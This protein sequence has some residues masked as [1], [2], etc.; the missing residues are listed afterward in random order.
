MQKFLAID[1]NDIN[2]ELLHQLVKIYYPNFLFLKAKNGKYGIELAT[3]EKP[4]LIL[5]DILMPEMNGYEVCEILKNTPE[6]KHIPILMVSALGNDPTERTKGL[7]VGA[8]AFISKPFRQTELQA[9]I[10]VALRI[11]TVEDL[12]RNRNRNLEVQIKSQTNKYLQSEE[13]FLQISEHAMEFYWEVDAEGIFTYVSPLVEKTL[14]ISHLEIIGIKKYQDVFHISQ[15]KNTTFEEDL[16]FSDLEVELNVRGE[17]IWLSISGFSIFDKKGISIGKRGVCYTITKRKKAEIALNENMQQ[18]EN[19]QKK[20]KSLNVEITLVEERERRRIAENL[21]DSLGQTLSLAF[22]KL[23]SIDVDSSPSIKKIIAE[24]SNLL[25]I[26]ISESRSLTYDLSPPILYEL[27]LIPAFKW[28]LEQIE[29]KY[30]I[31]TTLIG[32]DQQIK[33]QKEYN[34][35]L[36]RIVCELLMNV[37]KHA[38]ANLIEVEILW[39]KEF[40]CIIVRDNGIGFKKEL[41]TTAGTQGGFGLMSIYE[42][43]DSMKGKFEIESKPGEGTEAKIIIPFSKNQNYEN[44]SIG[45]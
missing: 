16:R 9:Q 8:D 14:R 45:N 1:D 37:I 11:K 21:H 40:Y 22:L 5:L 27:G 34:I 17:N 12:L 43:I 19:Y 33:V 4:E 2:L 29:E 18:I 26:A 31:N 38:K 39:E 13:R 3:K 24:T 36:Y 10:N 32:E 44:K 23:S 20:L 41:K 7:N 6:T 25:D 35:F 42:R 15:L 30:V 28:K